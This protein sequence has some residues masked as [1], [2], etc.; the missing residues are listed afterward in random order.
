[1]LSELERRAVVH[2]QGLEDRAS[3]Q[4]PFVVDTEHRLVDRHDAATELGERDER[5]ETGAASGAPIAASSGR[6]LTH[7]SSTSSEGSES[8]TMPPPTQRWIAPSTTA[9]VR[10]V[11]ARSTS[12][13]G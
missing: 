6:A 8:Q 1:M 7:D 10:I 12:P 11:R 13:F 9:N 2:A 5:H 4:H 3:A